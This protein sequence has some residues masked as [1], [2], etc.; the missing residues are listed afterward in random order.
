MFSVRLSLF[1]KQEMHGAI[2]N[3][4]EGARE[5]GKPDH[6]LPHSQIVKSKCAQY[7]GA[8]YL[9]IEAVFM[10]DQSQVGGFIDDESFEAIVEN[11]QLENVS[12]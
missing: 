12:K 1:D 8:R 9:D 4:D 5:D 10:V 7:G 3:D 11:R 2:C 6:I